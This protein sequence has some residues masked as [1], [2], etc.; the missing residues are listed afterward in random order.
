[1]T[2][3]RSVGE[4]SH[5]SDFLY[6]DG[7]VRQQSQHLEHRS[8]R[9]VPIARAFVTAAILRVGIY[10]G[11]CRFLNLFDSFALPCVILFTNQ[12]ACQPVAA[13]PWIPVHGG[14]LPPVVLGQ[15]WFE[16]PAL[17]LFVYALTQ[18]W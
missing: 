14:P 13:Y 15:C 11:L 10:K 4:G 18:V 9:S 6:V 5:P 8:C 12:Y 16:N 17:Y 3:V 2:D 7:T 1:M